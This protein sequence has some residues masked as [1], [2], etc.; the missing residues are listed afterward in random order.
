ML[1]ISIKDKSD[2]ES[3]G[4]KPEEADRDSAEKNG[5]AASTD[6]KITVLVNIGYI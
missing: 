4:E 5:F 3:T 1:N 2:T 6:S